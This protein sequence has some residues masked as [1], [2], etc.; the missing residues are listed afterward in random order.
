MEE[1]LREKSSGSMSGNGVSGLC[2]GFAGILEW[3][4]RS[5][6]NSYW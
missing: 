6:A 1:P 2:G 5:G 3:E 4:H